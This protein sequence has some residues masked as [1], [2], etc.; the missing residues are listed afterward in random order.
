MEK[1]IGEKQEPKVDNS[2]F[3]PS[4]IFDDV[5]F[6]SSSL[7]PRILVQQNSS[8]LSDKLSNIF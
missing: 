5:V 4:F 3:E 8:E 6:Q 7:P 2:S 1:V